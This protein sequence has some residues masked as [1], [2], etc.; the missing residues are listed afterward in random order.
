MGESVCTNPMA[1]LTYKQKKQIE[2]TVK[3]LKGDI[4][5]GNNEAIFS[6]GDRAATFPYGQSRPTRTSTESIF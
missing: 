1:T 6:Q 5:I 2:A 4:K 3:A